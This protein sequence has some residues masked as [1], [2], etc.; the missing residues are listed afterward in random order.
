MK[1]I[2]KLLSVIL[3]ATLLATAFAFTTSAASLGDVNKD[4]KVAISDAKLVLQ[5]VAKMKTLSAEQEKIADING[6]GKIDLVDAKWI[7]QIVVGL[8]NAD[9]TEKKTPIKWDYKN[10]KAYFT[11][12]T[13]EV[14]D[15]VI[16]DSLDNSTLVS[17]EENNGRIVATYDNGSKDTRFRCDKCGKYT[18]DGSCKTYEDMYKCSYCGRTDCNRSTSWDFTCEFCGQFV[19]ANTCHHCAGETAL[20]KARREEWNKTH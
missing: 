15:F 2:T 11:A 12:S 17:I 9:G 7:L 1:K 16:N 10:N 19:K 4:G 13:G 8:R 5:S 20:D 6:D 3:V 14:I 18:C